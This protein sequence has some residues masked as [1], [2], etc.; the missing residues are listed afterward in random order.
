MR[1]IRSEI[2]IEASADEVWRVLTDFPAFPEWNPFIRKAEGDL[3]AGQHIAV[4]LQPPGHRAISF[5]PK[6]LSVDP[7]RGFRWLGHVMMPG[8]FDGEHIHEIKPLGPGRVRYVQRE[9]FHGVLLPFFG[10]MLR[11]AQ[12]G[13]AG[14]NAALKA[15]VERAA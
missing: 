4:E 11:D 8:I 2:E 10:G 14:M 12:R 9:Q 13:F 5:K 3:V 6:L 1:E 15:R 7:G